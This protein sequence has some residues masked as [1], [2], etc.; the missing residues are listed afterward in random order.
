[1]INHLAVIHLVSAL[2]NTKYADHGPIDGHDLES[3]HNSLALFLLLALEDDMFGCNLEDGIDV[4][5][6]AGQH[7]LCI[8]AYVIRWDEMV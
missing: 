2:D 1:M 6:K 5:G 4:A 8:D 3:Q 7:D